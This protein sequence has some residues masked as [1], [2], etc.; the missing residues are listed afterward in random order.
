MGAAIVPNVWR[1]VPAT[2]G[3]LGG[4][5][6]G[7]AGVQ[8][9]LEAAAKLFARERHED[10]R[11]AGL[12]PHHPDVVTPAAVAAGVAL[13]LRQW[14]EASH[15]DRTLDRRSDVKTRPNLRLRAA[16]RAVGRTR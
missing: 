13:G 7:V 4:F 6:L 12:E 15:E 5:D 11:P 9:L 3:D 8:A 2:V 14:P 16:A 10:P 1:L